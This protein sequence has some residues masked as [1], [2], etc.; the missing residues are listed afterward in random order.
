M[1]IAEKAAGK[2]ASVKKVAPYAELNG[3]E[4]ITVF[5]D[6]VQKK[7]GKALFALFG[8][9]V[10]GGHHNSRFDIDEKV[11][12]NAADFLLALHS[13]IIDK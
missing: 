5:M 6:R 11:I 2:L 12:Y 10:G 13:E 3:S 4:D 9:P 1:P 8:T 7:G